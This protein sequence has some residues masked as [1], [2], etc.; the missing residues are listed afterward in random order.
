MVNNGLTGGRQNRVFS[1]S[2]KGRSRRL[3][4]SVLLISY[5][6]HGAYSFVHILLGNDG[7]PLRRFLP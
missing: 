5:F 6:G 4:H 7:Y 3:R 1:G 2:G